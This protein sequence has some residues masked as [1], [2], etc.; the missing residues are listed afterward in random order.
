MKVSNTHHVTKKGTVKKNPPRKDNL[1]YEVWE[2]YSDTASYSSNTKRDAEDW[3]RINLTD[4]NFIIRKTT[5][6]TV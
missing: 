3:A 1:S 4:S 6:S 2:E 5:R